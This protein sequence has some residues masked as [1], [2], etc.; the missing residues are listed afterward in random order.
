MTTRYE[1]T[2]EVPNDMLR[3]AMTSWAKPA[4]NK[5]RIWVFFALCLIGG[6]A[7]GVL[8]NATGLFQVLPEGFLLGTLVG[9]YLGLLVWL[10]FHRTQLRKLSAMSEGQLEKQGPI[11]ATYWAEGAE[12]RT[13]HTS[14]RSGWAC[15]DQVIAMDD[16]V[17]LRS[18]AVIYP[19]PHDALPEGVAPAT[20]LAD[21]Q[22]WQKAGQ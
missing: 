15:Y 16:A 8:G 6:V 17:A 2:Y 11:H 7:L 20:F 5:R 10:I 9:F 21:L 1:M 13:K 22:R 19:I 4:Q 18:G 12:V 14:T 3:R